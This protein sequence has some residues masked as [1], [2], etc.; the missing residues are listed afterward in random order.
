MTGAR[1]SQ[2]S[3]TFVCLDEWLANAA[4]R[5]SLQVLPW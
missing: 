3:C 5:E 1:S 4:E 2:A